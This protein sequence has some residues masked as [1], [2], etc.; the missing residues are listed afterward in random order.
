[1]CLVQEL[2]T[3]LTGALEKGLYYEDIEHSNTTDMWSYHFYYGIIDQIMKGD[4]GGVRPLNYVDLNG[5]APECG[6]YDNPQKVD[7]Q[8][9]RI[10]QGIGITEWNDGECLFGPP[11]PY[12]ALRMFDYDRWG[13]IPERHYR[14]MLV[15]FERNGEV[16]YDVW[17]K[18]EIVLSSVCRR[19]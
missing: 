8:G 10:I 9:G 2:H 14:S 15:H 13:F 12:G 4:F 16:L 19:R 7:T 17:P 11:N 3:S 5:K 18:K 1:M 6:K